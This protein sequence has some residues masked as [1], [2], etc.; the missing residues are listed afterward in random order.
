MGARTSTQTRRTDAGV[1]RPPAPGEPA[2]DFEAYTDTGDR[3]RLSDFRG[4]KVVL[5]FYPKD[6]TPGCT[7]Q[8]CGFRDRYEG[9]ADRGAVVLGVSPDDAASHRRFREK[10]SLPFPLLVD[11]DA[12]IA[13]LYG[14]WGE[15]SMY[16]RKYM[17]VIRSHFVIGEDGRVVEARVK[18]SPKDS[19]EL[20]VAALD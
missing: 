19:V 13:R 7:Q 12:R 11:E 1:G 10:Y 20:A 5:Y 18:V 3:I 14:V 17:G 9:I 16:G 8:A 2:P 6:M 15:K 4:R